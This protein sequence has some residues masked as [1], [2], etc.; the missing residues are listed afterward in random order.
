[1]YTIRRRICTSTY[2]LVYS[3]QYM[4]LKVLS[5]NKEYFSAKMHNVAKRLLN[6]RLNTFIKRYNVRR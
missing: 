1:M 3:L 6:L 2:I 5:D 4:S